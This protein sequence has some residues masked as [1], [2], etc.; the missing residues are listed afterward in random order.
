MYSLRIYLAFSPILRRP[1]TGPGDRALIALADCPS[2]Q[3]RRSVVK[4][5]GSRSVRSSR[6]TVS[7]YT[8]RQWFPNTQQSRFLTACRHLQKL[9]LPS[10]FDTDLSFLMMWN[11]RSYTT[12]FWIEDILGGGGGKTYS[13]PSYI[14][15]GGLGTQ[16]PPLQDLYALASIPLW[17]T[18]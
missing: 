17:C 8:L 1:C 4:S 5:G 15:L 13:D 2:I 9:V 3:R 7:D 10:I 12:T 6:Q 11:M 16:Q 18:G 14:F